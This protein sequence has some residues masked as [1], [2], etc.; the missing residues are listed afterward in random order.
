MTLKE[1][2]DI[3]VEIWKN[4]VDLDSHCYLYTLLR[5]LDILAV[6]RLIVE[7]S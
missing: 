1:D 4:D 5:P 7:M 6:S 3:E 2:S